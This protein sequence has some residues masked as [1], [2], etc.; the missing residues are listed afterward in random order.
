[1]YVGS[2]DGSFHAVDAASGKRAWRF[3]AKG[4]VRDTALVDGPRVVFGTMDGILYALDR[5]TGKEIWEKNLEMSVTSSP[6]RIGDR[7]VVGT[8]ASGLHA[9]APETGEELWKRSFWG[10]WV[11]ST[12]V[13]FGDFFYIGSSDLR[14]VTGYDREGRILWRTDVFGSPWGRPAV[15]E[16]R[17]YIGAEGNSPYPVR[18]LGSFCALDRATGRIVWRWVSPDLPGVV[19][20]GFVGGPA[21]AGDLVVVAGLDGS[22]S[23][24]PAE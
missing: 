14:R 22:L 17:V 19:Q 4:M 2:G 23:A 7:L 11:E 10:S 13:P 21:L 24:F 18:N 15:T 9:L 12:A 6:A 1:V 3:A 8:R 20:T 16:K 5:A